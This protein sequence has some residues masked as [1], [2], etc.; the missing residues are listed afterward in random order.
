MYH[1]LDQGEL[2][3][4][5]PMLCSEVALSG[6][7]LGALCGVQFSQVRTDENQRGMFITR[8]VGVV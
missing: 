6:L 5:T 7:S 3:F 1:I 4:Q 8:L 2:I